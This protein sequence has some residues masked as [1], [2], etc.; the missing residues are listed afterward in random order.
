MDANHVAMLRDAINRLVQLTDQDWE[1]LIPHLT[2][3]QLTIESLTNSHLIYLPLQGAGFSLRPLAFMGK[4]WQKA[5][6]T[7][8]AGTRG[9]H[10]RITYS[11]PG[12]SLPRTGR[13]CVFGS[14]QLRPRNGLRPEVYK[15][16]QIYSFGY[17]GMRVPLGREKCI[18]RWLTDVFI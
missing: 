12:R 2:Y 18:R 3:S 14:Q 8:C 1:I 13:S 11:Y 17:H 15:R 6:R 7:P 4:V 9:T 10:G 16:F 5:G